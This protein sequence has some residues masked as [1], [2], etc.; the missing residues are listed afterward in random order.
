[1]NIIHTPPYFEY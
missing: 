1:V